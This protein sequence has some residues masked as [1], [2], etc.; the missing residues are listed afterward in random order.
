MNK[1]FQGSKKKGR[2]KQM[3]AKQREKERHY[4]H[5]VRLR[6][7]IDKG[8]IETAAHLMGVRLK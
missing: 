7:A 1:Q 6:E 5:Q 4:M 8:D 2:R 3:E